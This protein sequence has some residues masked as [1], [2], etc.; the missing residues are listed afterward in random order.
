MS[1][2]LLVHPFRALLADRIP[3][4]G[5]AANRV[6]RI[7]AATAAQHRDRCRIHDNSDAA[8]PPCAIAGLET[9]SRLTKHLH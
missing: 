7:T 2:Y 9:K 1:L 3:G 4:V 5:V 6:A 8:F